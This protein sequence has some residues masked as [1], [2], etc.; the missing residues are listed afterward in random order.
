MLTFGLILLA[1]QAEA[2]IWR[3][4]NNPS[5]DGDVLQASTLF[6]NSNTATNP[7]AAAGDSIY[8]EP[9]AT[10]YNGFNVNKAN[11]VIMGHGYLLNE[12]TGLQANTNNAKVASIEFSL[13]STGSSVY[14]LEIP[15]LYISAGNVTVSRCLLSNALLYNIGT[16]LSGIRIDKCYID[17]YLYTSSINAAVTSISIAVENCIFSTQS[18]SSYY[19]E[20]VNLTQKVRGLF[21]NNTLNGSGTFNCFNFYVANNIFVGNTNFGNATQSGNNVYR[22]NLLS[23]NSNT[24][25]TIVTNTMPNSNNQFAVNMANVFTGTPNNVTNGT[26]IFNNHI[27]LGTSNEGRF[28]LA[29]MSTA[30]TA[31]E[32][33]TTFN[34][35]T[36]TTPACGAYGATDPY[37]KAGIP[38]IP[39]IYSLTVPATIPNGASTL[40]I[41]V[42]S[43]SNN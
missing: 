7:E 27:L 32:T 28:Q 4:N 15:T 24:S 23:Y 12:N 6:D 36:V 22:N 38:P 3:V 18:T 2:K 17:Y 41:S 9:S 11:I 33:G 13:N 8:V 21:R 26:N 30:L 16:N 25:N 1:I 20:G 14:G 42:S 31:G 19:T 40:T 5:L 35:A 43:R 34:T 39:T 37:R 10:Q 29:P